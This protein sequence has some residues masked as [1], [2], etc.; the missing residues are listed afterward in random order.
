MKVVSAFITMLFLQLAFTAM[1]P[2]PVR[3]NA[4]REKRNSWGMPY[5]G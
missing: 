5:I 1:R 4:K 3:I 2:Q